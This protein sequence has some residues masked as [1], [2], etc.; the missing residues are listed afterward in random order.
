MRMTVGGDGDGCGV[1]EGLHV[2][3]GDLDLRSVR[4][5]LQR[6]EPVGRMLDRLAKNFGTSKSSVVLVT[7]M[8]TAR[9][10]G[11]GAVLAPLR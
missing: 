1:P 3:L 5:F 6:R 11:G 9:V 4:P 7:S 8:T 10:S 2:G